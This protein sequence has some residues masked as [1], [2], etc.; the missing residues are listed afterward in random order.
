MKKL[1]LVALSVL[2]LGSCFLR[3]STKE[4]GETPL[5]TDLVTLEKQITENAFSFEYLSFKGSGKFDGMGIQQN[6]TLN[7]KMKRHEIVWI[8]A[9][10]MLGIEVARMLVT[11]DSAYIIQNFPE[12]SYREFSLDSLS[13]LLSVPLSVTQLQDLFLGNPLLPYDPAQIGMRGDSIIVEKRVSA[14]L[15]HEFFVPQRPKIVRNYLQSLQE[16]GSADVHYLD[17]QT[18]NNKQMPVKVNIFVRRSDLTAN[19]D[20]HYTNISLDSIAQFPFRKPTQ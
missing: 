20:L 9:Q 16:D 17:F 15:I 1:S 11:K 8:S 14:Y 12:R 13:Q 18:V 19:L 10:A 2:M 4:S 6:L 5:S 7:F 3:K